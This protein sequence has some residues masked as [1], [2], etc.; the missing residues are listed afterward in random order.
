MQFNKFFSL[1]VLLLSVCFSPVQAQKS[2]ID[3]NRITESKVEHML[4]KLDLLDTYDLDSLRPECS[5]ASDSSFHFISKSFVIKADLNTVWKAYKTISP[6]DAWSGSLVSFGF[7]YSKITGKLT[8]NTDQYEGMQVGQIVFINLHF[9]DRL[10]SLPVAHE[11]TEVNDQEKYMRMCYLQ[12][13]KSQGSQFIHFYSTPEGY[14]KIVH[15]TYYKSDSPFRD[16]H[17]YPPLHNMFISEFHNNVAQKIMED[18]AAAK[19]QFTASK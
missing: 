12:N 14:T 8:Y 16:K 7:L 10:F 13:G 1:L 2:S 6:E 5:I 11:I 19:E 15:N 9:L 17:L 3:M 18:E 4:E